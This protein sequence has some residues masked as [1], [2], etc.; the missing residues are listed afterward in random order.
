MLKSLKGTNALTVLFSPSKEAHKTRMFFCPYR[1]N[2]V[3][4]YQGEIASIQ[5]GFNPDHSPQFF[6]RPQR[7]KYSD[8]INYIFVSVEGESPTTFWI[9]DQY[10]DD[11]EVKLYHCYNC[12]APQ[13]YY[14]DKGATTYND[15]K[16]I[17]PGDDY[18]CYKCGVQSIFMGIVKIKDAD[19]RKLTGY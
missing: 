9:Q 13:I 14:N 17:R 12:Q 4:S 3:G 5:P 2:I 1:R 8:N 11:R 7:Q 6:V 18:T 15:T 10:F 19:G 16:I